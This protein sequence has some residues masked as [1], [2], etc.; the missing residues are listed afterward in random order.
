MEGEREVEG[1]LGER[2]VGEECMKVGLSKM[3][4]LC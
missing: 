2:Q 1:F 4:I 3:G